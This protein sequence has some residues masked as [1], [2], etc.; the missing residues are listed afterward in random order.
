MFYLYGSHSKK[1][2]VWST[3]MFAM[4]L[5]QRM[6]RLQRP[7]QGHHTEASPFYFL[8]SHLPSNQARLC[9]CLTTCAHGQVYQLNHEDGEGHEAHEGPACYESHEDQQGHEGQVQGL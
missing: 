3:S 8:G 4:N 5:Q 1:Y 9:H 6:S 7:P 2:V